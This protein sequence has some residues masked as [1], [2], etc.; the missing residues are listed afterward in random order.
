MKKYLVFIFIVFSIFESCV[1]QKKEKMTFAT[2]KTDYGNITIKLYN[3]TPKHKENFIKLAKDDFF[4]GVL[5]HRVIGNFMIQTGDPDSKNAQKGAALG[6]GGPGYKIP[7]EIV[8]SLIHK[9]GAVAAARQG[10]QVNPERKSSGS[11]FYIVQGQKFSEE[12]LEATEKRFRKKF[13]PKQKDAYTTVGG[14][15]HLDGSYTVFGEVVEGL[16]VVDE[17]AA[18]ETDRRNRPV[19]DIRINDVKI[20]TKRVKIE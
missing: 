7:A 6:S 15:P 12:Q 4:D 8:P 19:K 17:I 11:Q 13:T 9:K 1:S 20:S 2:L 16:S 3:E 5:F 10:D 14:T 18:V